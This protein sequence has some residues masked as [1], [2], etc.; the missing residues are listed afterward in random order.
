MVNEEQLMNITEGIEKA[1]PTLVGFK[2]HF[3]KNE[4]ESVRQFLQ[5]ESKEKKTQTSSEPATSSNDFV[6]INNIGMNVTKISS[7]FYNSARQE[8]YIILEENYGDPW[9]WF[10]PLSEGRFILTGLQKALN[11]KEN[12]NFHFTKQKSN[13][14]WDLF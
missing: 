2:D 13:S 8:I 6:L 11:A 14:F 5:P 4:L 3:C 9:H 12:F 1:F 7:F 10:V